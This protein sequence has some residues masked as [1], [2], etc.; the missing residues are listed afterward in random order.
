MGTVDSYLVPG[1]RV[2]RQGD[3]WLG[4]GEYDKGDDRG[5]GHWIDWFLYQSDTHW[6]ILCYLWE[7]TKLWE[8]QDLGP[9]YQ[10]N[11]RRHTQCKKLKIRL[12]SGVE[13]NWLKPL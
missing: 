9:K 4:V 5:G 11:G 12:K 3:Y 1:C 7:L 8:R 13:N 6:A 10:S 2:I